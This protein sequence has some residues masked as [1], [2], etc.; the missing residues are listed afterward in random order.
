M[1]TDRLQAPNGPAKESRPGRLL[2]RNRY[3]S[4]VR[5]RPGPRRE[6]GPLHEFIRCGLTAGPEDMPRLNSVKSEPSAKAEALVE[7]KPN[8]KAQP[9]VKAEPTAK[10]T[11][12]DDVKVDTAGESGNVEGLG[13]CPD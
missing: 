6:E 11:K 4:Q 5:W 1:Y 3:S 12:L 13:E 10:E 2:C 9:T 8:V 7:A